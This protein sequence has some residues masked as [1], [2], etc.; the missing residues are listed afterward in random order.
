MNLEVCSLHIDYILCVVK[1]VCNGC[2][3]APP[4][5]LLARCAVRRRTELYE[6]G[7]AGA[8]LV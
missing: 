4:D 8:G 3:I 5:I 2:A 1:R 7:F 6:T